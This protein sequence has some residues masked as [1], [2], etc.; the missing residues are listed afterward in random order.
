MIGK[1][2][3]Y[4]HVLLLTTVKAIWTVARQS[5]LQSNLFDNVHVEITG[6]VHLK[7]YAHFLLYTSINKFI[8]NTFIIIYIWKILPL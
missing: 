7:G 1:E 3:E 4:K 5:L 8:I 2:N 6:I